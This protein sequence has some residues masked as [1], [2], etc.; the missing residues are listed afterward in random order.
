MSAYSVRLY[1]SG[2]GARVSTPGS[3][4]RCALETATFARY[5]RRVLRN[6]FGSLVVPEEKSSRNAS[7]PSRTVGGSAGI[8]VRSRSRNSAS[9]STVPVHPMSRRAGASP[10]SSLITSPMPAAEMT[11]TRCGRGHCGSIVADTARYPARPATIRAAW[12]ALATL[13]AVIGMPPVSGA[14]DGGAAWARCAAS[15]TANTRRESSTRPA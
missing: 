7:S 9:G 11:C 8:A 5:C 3:G 13:T 15:T 10:A 1:D 2:P 12:K 6:A 4:S 14:G